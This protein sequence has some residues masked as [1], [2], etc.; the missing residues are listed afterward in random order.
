MHA[1]SREGNSGSWCPFLDALPGGPLAFVYREHLTLFQ[2]SLLLF[3]L[4]IGP[5][6]TL[7]AEGALPES[8]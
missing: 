8:L 1:G 4:T 5:I 6:C 7:W 2:C 3:P